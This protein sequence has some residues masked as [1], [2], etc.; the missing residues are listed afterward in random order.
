MPLQHHTGGVEGVVTSD[1]PF[2]LLNVASNGEL[3]VLGGCHF[4]F[5]FIQISLLKQYIFVFCILMS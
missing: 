3:L 5:V 1:P 2:S 4:N